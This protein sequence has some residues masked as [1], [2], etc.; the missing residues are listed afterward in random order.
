MKPGADYVLGA[1]VIKSS[2]NFPDPLVPLIRKIPF[3]VF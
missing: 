2:L 3:F 1:S